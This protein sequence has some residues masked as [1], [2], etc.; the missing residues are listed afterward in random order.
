MR[1]VA[2]V[3]AMF[4]VTVSLSADE[5][6][7]AVRVIEE[8]LTTFPAKSVPEGVEVLTGV[9]ESCHYLS[10]GTLEKAAKYTIDEVTAA[11]KGDHVRFVFAEPLKLDVLGEKFE[12]SEVIFADASGFWLVSEESIVRCTKYKHDR[13]EPFL[14]WYHQTLPV[15]PDL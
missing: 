2:T 9:V 6:A 5:P 13:W 1:T 10:D 15:D 4:L 12:V 14:K 11:R 3:T 8:A 7:K